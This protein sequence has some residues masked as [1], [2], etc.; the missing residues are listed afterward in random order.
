MTDSTRPVC[1]CPEPRACYAAGYAAGKDK[2]YFE[3]EMVLQ[4]ESRAAGCGCHPCR[5][6]RTALKIALL[7]SI[8]P[9]LE[10]HYH[11]N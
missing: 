7:A 4:D 11:H 3:I 9:A 1:D 10:G 6:K 2:G 5:I 8:S